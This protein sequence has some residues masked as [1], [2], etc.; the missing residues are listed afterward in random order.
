MENPIKM[1]DLGVPLF[2][3]TSSWFPNTFCLIP[4]LGEMRQFDFFEGLKPPTRLCHSSCH[5]TTTLSHQ[6][7]FSAERVASESCLPNLR[8]MPFGWIC[9]VWMQQQQK[10]KHIH[11]VFGIF[12]IL[13][14]ASRYQ[15][16]LI[17]LP[18]S[19]TS[20]E[21]HRVY[22]LNTPGT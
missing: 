3:E 8:F 7:T 1:D 18:G 10:G 12:Q 21:M 17:I 14:T 13:V 2:S 16:R 5:V 15:Y 20:I 6:A 19:N 22:R 4:L 11:C 9:K